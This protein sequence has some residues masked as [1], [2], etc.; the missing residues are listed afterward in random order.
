QLV[1]QARRL[2]TMTDESL[3]IAALEKPTPVERGAFLDAA[4]ASDPAQRERLDILLAGHD[5]ATGILDHSAPPPA[6]APSNRGSPPAER[7]GAVL[8]G[9]YKLI[10]E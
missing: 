2:L 5:Q 3:F 9:R 7:A 10:E 4:C 6:P 8:A 1:F